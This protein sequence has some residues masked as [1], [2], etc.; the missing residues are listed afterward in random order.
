MSAA[1][2]SERLSK[3]TRYWILAAILA[4][5]GFL[6]IYQITI[7]PPGLYADEA[8]NGSNVLEVLET[9]DIHVFYPENNGREGL[10]IDVAIPFIY[11]L[12]NEAWVL[13][14][15]AILFGLAT[16]WGMYLLGTELF[17]ARAGLLAAFLMATSFWHINFS[18][19]AFRA[20]AAPCMFT[21]ALWSLLASFRRL[22]EGKA[23]LHLILVSGVIYGLGFYTYIAYRVTPV[24]M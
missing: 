15:P 7:Y 3:H 4:L 12:G 17:S 5:A 11:W 14:I 18:R 22:R 8:M 1:G 20:I 24:L 19:I 2:E 16:V 9:H 10:Y 6:R 13:R 21:W 23:W